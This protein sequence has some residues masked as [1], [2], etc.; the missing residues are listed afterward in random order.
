MLRRRRHVGGRYNSLASVILYKL[1]KSLDKSSKSGT[2]RKRASSSVATK[3]RKTHTKKTVKKRKKTKSRKKVKKGGK[4]RRVTRKKG[5]KAK[6]GRKSAPKR[7]VKKLCMYNR[8]LRLLATK[9]E[10]F[11]PQ[12][13]GFY[14]P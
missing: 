7:I 6:K 3:R 9:N 5:K 12:F 11:L 10:G 4:K 8:F 13:K 14:I 2:K 1:N